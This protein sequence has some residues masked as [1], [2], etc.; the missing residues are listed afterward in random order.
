[1]KTFIVIMGLI[2]MLGAR[3]QVAPNKTDASGKK[4]GHWI[5]LDEKQ[6]KLYD[7]NFADGKPVGKF[8]YFYDSGIPWAITVFSDNGKIARTKTFDAGGKLTGEGKYIEEKRDSV[9]KFYNEE[10]KIISEET[11]VNGLKSGNCKVFYHSGGLAEEK[12]WKNGVADG[13]WKKYFAN[14]QLKYNGMLVKGKVEGRVTFYYDSGQKE[15]EGLYKGDLKD[16]DW[17]YY[18]E[19]G[20]LKRTDKFIE[21]VNQNPDRDVIPKEEEEKEKKKYEGFEIKDPGGDGNSPH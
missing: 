13:V 16:G 14:G 5:K 7:G 20:K 6:K 9:W 8:T 4:Q 15:A 11:Y 10:G 2:G 1:M 18:T 12:M 19:E 17:N 21:G 3:G